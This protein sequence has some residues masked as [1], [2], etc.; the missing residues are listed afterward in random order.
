[1][2]VSGSLV[3]PNTVAQPG[4]FNFT[5]P[6]SQ[7]T[8]T[9]FRVQGGTPPKASWNHIEIDANGNPLINNTTLNVSIGN[10]EHAKYF[11]SLRPGSNITSFEIPK[12]MDDFIQG[13]AIPQVNYR[14]NSLNQ[15]GLA[16]KI[17]DPT[18]PGRSY[19]LPS[20]WTKWLE[21]TAIKGSGKV[22]K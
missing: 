7:E 11:Q 6:L 1:M 18:T 5:G 2:I 19:E 14:S 13:E 21:E 3:V 15:G 22:I 16:P 8:S 17:V 20:I 12:W 9:L 10:V 4:D